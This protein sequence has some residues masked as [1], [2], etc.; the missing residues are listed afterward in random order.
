MKVTT[1]E[2]AH[3]ITKLK[4]DE[5]FGSLLTFEMTIS[6]REN[7]KGK[8][9]AFK[10]IYE[11][12]TTV[13]QS[14]KEEN[15]NE[16]IDLLI[17]QFSNVVKKL[18]N[19]NTTGSNAQNLINYQR[20]DGENNT[21]RFNENSNRRNSDYGRKKEGEGR[22]FKCR[23]YEGIDDNEEDN[24]MN[25]FT[26]HITKTDSDDES[27]SFE[28]NYDN[29]LTFEELKVMWKEDT[30]ARAIQKLCSFDV[31]YPEVVAIEAMHCEAVLNTGYKVEK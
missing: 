31:G 1:I 23:E 25:A 30:E 13:N 7:K 9:V 17:K 18:K 10:S 3:D 29:E 21:R 12:E 14:D 15:M 5:L 24:D 4:L 8:G 11:D 19:L 22:V 20:K 28:K 26:V 6:H 27:K 16:S 2:E